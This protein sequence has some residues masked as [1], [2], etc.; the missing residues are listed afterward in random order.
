MRYAQITVQK[1]ILR[2]Q[3]EVNV[4]MCACVFAETVRESKRVGTVCN[5]CW[6]MIS[7]GLLSVE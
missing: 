3:K 6:I 1:S 2:E 7:A 4:C 5:I